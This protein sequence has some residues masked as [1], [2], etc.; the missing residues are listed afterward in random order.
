MRRR[1][2]SRAGARST[3]ASAS[4]S[5]S[6]DSAWT[7]ARDDA[8]AATGPNTREGASCA[9]RRTRDVH[10]LRSATHLGQSTEGRE[11]EDASP[12]AL[13]VGDDGRVGGERGLDHVVVGHPGLHQHAPV[14]ASPSDDAGGANEQPDRLLG[15]S[16]TR[17]E[18]LLIEL[19]ERQQLDPGRD[20]VGA[21]EHGLGS[22][23][24]R[25][26]RQRGGRGIDLR[27]RHPGQQC[28]HLLAHPR[29]PR[30]ATR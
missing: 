20:R 2:R 3:S 16:V 8:P 18:Q 25:G 22:H 29:D 27:H 28:S 19:Q 30:P 14:A 9:Q 11:S 5:T 26:R 1:P 21:V 6:T 24:H 10:R 12:G 23:Q 4:Q 13:G 7:S 17:R 15:S